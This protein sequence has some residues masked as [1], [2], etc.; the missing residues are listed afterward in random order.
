M[1]TACKALSRIAA[2]ARTCERRP[3]FRNATQTVFGQGPVPA[4]IILVGEQPGDA[5]DKAGLPFVGPAGR[6]LDKAMLLARIARNR[7][8]ITNAV[9]HFKNVPRGKRSFIAQVD[10]SEIQHAGGLE[11]FPSSGRL[12]LFCDPTPGTP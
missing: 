6:I 10:F 7:V 5:E 4:A 12:L 2:E 1:P 8:Y 9:K 3:L 11:G